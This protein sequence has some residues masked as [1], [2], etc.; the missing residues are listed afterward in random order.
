MN[1]RRTHFPV[2]CLKCE[3]QWKTPRDVSRLRCPK[4]ASYYVEMLY[5]VPVE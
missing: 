2:G 3:H 1:G 5:E 4:C